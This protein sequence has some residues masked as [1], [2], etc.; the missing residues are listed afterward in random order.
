M[1][2]RPFSVLVA[3]VAFCAGLMAQNEPFL[4][5]WEFNLAKSNITRGVP[6][7]S[8]TFVM[9]PEPG[10]FKSVRATIRGDGTTNVEIHHYNFDGNFH[11]T[12]GGDPRELSFKRLDQYT[13]EETARRN[14]NGQIT[15][16]KRRLEVSKDG[17]TKTIRSLSG[18]NDV[19]VY[20]KK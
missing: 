7:K 4:G 2:W 8:Q 19:R 11:Q 20:D 16:S 6:P 1:L 17:K 5:I 15:I 18:D 9:V 13:I 10:G 12:E 3:I 14:R